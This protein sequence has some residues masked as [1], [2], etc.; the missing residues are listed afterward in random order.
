MTHR[1]GA[2]KSFFLTTPNT[3]AAETQ[4]VRKKQG[5][6]K[7][8][9][10]T[11]AADEIFVTRLPKFPDSPQKKTGS[12]VADALESIIPEDKIVVRSMVLVANVVT[13][14]LSCW[15]PLVGLWCVW[16]GL[17]A[18]LKKYSN[19]KTSYPSCHKK[20]KADNEISFKFYLERAL[21]HVG[22]FVR[23]TR[24]TPKYEGDPS[25]CAQ[26]VKTEGGLT[27]KKKLPCD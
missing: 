20:I 5:N 3:F 6:A 26:R 12:C 1:A 23:I 19:P 9:K 4:Q 16:H 2:N 13:L 18:T 25:N 22:K 10:V 7:K 15:W 27:F 11:F 8:K 14:F 17:S 24:S 21:G